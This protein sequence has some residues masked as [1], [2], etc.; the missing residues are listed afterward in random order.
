MDILNYFYVFVDIVVVGDNAAKTNK[1]CE[2]KKSDKNLS[3]IFPFPKEYLI[4]LE[5]IMSL[6]SIF[7]FFFQFSYL[8]ITSL[9]I[10]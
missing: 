9:N 7:I 4:T 1:R 3:S 6:I 10:W 5:L 8:F 2:Y